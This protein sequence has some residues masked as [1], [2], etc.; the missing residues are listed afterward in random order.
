MLSTVSMQG[1]SNDKSITLNEVTIDMRTGPQPHGYDLLASFMG[2][3]LEAAIFRRFATLNA[4]N[5]LYLQAEPLCP[6]ARARKGCE[7]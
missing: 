5:I 7:G 1:D 3:Y 2:F 6:R 4:K